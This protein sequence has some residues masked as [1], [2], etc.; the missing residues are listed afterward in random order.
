M[1]LHQFTD[2]TG[3]GQC[4][5]KEQPSS[6]PAGSSMCHAAGQMPACPGNLPVPSLKL[7]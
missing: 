1:G 5:T 4:Q 6:Q 7:C 2:T 3:P